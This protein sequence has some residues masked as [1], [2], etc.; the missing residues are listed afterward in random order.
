MNAGDWHYKAEGN[1]HV[2]LFN[3]HGQV[4]RMKK[5]NSSDYDGLAK[6]SCE[7]SS[8]RLYKDHLDF[9]T[10]V[11]GPLLKNSD[12]CEIP[13]VINL[14]AE[15]VVDVGKL[16]QG[17]RPQF[18]K[19]KNLHCNQPALLMSDFSIMKPCHNLIDNDIKLSADV[20]CIELKTKKGFMSNF[21]P[22][23]NKSICQ[24]CS[25][26]LYRARHASSINIKMSNYCPIDL[27]TGNKFLMKQALEA[28]VENPRNNFRMFKNGQLVYSQQIVDQ[29]ALSNVDD[30]ESRIKSL[31]CLADENGGKS[32]LN[33]CFYDIIIEALLLPIIEQPC[34]NEPADSTSNY[35]CQSNQYN[36][37]KFAVESSDSKFLSENSV[38]SLPNSSVLG[39]ILS[40]QK[41]S[42][43]DSAQYI[44]D[45]YHNLISSQSKMSIDD[46][47]C[48]S[49]WKA[50]GNF[51]A[52]KNDD[53]LTSDETR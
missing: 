46:P 32:D 41:I 29:L 35:P 48:T 5:D 17:E 30:C 16:I 1:K 9:Q 47:Y 14:S 43:E 18:R 15:F 8:K 2:V 21:D 52:V 37:E 3:H 31:L 33:M 53:H 36:N 25:T 27:F 38:S 34:S 39:I 12:L 4:L 28:L 7:K 44:L 24:F 49:E 45:S 10:F 23:F 11:I 22:L 20:I 19:N 40:A 51:T 6:D 42:C 50:I 26:Q 13:S